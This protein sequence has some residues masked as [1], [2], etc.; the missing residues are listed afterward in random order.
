MVI[1]KKSKPKL[2]SKSL[3][4]GRPPL[5]KKHA[6]SLSSKATRTLIRKHHNV[7]KAHAKALETGDAALADQLSKQLTEDDLKNYQQASKTG[8]SAERG[9]DSSK[10]L[11]DWLKEEESEQN[12]IAYR[13]LEVGA[14]STTNAISRL[15]SKYE[16]TRI[17]LHSQGEG[18]VQQDFMERPLPASH[19][20]GNEDRFDIISLSLVL[21]FVGEP[22]GRGEMLKRCTEF[23]LPQPS[24][25]KRMTPCLFLVL[26]APCIIN[27]R[28]LT[29]LKLEEIMSS[30]GFTLLRKRA[31]AKL[32]YS[33]FR[34]DPSS[35]SGAQK[36]VFKKKDI[37][38]GRSRNNFAIVM[39]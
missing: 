30:I 18:I 33:L 5:V 35:V 38:S 15:P 3:A 36:S 22:V 7:L 29:E 8:Q 10:V 26:P 6:P 9:G 16:V 4:H 19:D 31:T 14:L 11:V 17:D 37:L 24:E 21:N 1:S 39:Q 28:Y 25:E 13:V 34:Y 12:T 27:S 2:R 20:G 32:Y 23:L